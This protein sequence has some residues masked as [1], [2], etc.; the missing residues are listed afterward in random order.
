[1]LLLKNQE[2]ICSAAIPYLV[3]FIFN[4]S[5]HPAFWPEVYQ[6]FTSEQK[7]SFLREKNSERAN[8]TLSGSDPARFNLPDADGKNISLK[9]VVSKNKITLV[10]Y[11]QAIHIIL[12]IIG[13]NY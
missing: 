2:S 8:S 5:A 1:L 4:P 12:K 10:H 9:E 13:M 6:N 11:G 7:N 3:Y